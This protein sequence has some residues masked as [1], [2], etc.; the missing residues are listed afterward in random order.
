MDIDEIVAELVLAK[1]KYQE[2]KDKESEIAKLMDKLKDYEKIKEDL[3]Y[4]KEK[5]GFDKPPCWKKR[6]L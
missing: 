2:I 5:Y 4:Y 6:V 3:A 1:E